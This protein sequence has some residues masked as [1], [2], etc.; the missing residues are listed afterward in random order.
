MH[1]NKYALSGVRTR[2]VIMNTTYLGMANLREFVFFL[3]ADLENFEGVRQLPHL[4]N[5]PILRPDMQGIQNNVTKSCV[6][7]W[8]FPVL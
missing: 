7:S 6:I 8:Q 1:I 4:S 2:R 5:M 3:F